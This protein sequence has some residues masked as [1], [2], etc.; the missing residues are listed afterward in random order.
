MG[1]KQSNNHRNNPTKMDKNNFPSSPHS[2][3]FGLLTSSNK[4]RPIAEPKGKR[5]SNPP[6]LFMRRREAV[7]LTGF[8]PCFILLTFWFFSSLSDS[9]KSQDIERLESLFAL[10][11]ETLPPFHRVCLSTE[12]PKPCT[13]FACRHRRRE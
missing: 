11:S 4:K 8:S 10:P 2:S 3:S 7:L 1:A 13:R 5:G 9:K 6:P 12:P